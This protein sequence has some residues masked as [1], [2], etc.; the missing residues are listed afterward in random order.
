MPAKLIRGEEVGDKVQAEILAELK[1]LRKKTEKV[2][3][4]ALIVVD[5]NP[6]SLSSVYSKEE[7]GKKLGFYT[8]VHRLPATVTVEEICTV[9]RR[10]N[11]EEQIHGLFC[12]LPLPGHLPENVI[13]DAIAPDKDV[14]GMHPL[15]A[16]KLLSEAR[17]YWPCRAYGFMQAIEF[18]KQPVYGKTAVLI[19]RSNNMGKPLALLLLRR[20]AAVTL[21]PTLT[22][23]LPEI[24]RSA[25]ILVTEAGKPGLIRGDWIKPGAVVIDASV[26]LRGEKLVGDLVLEEVVKVAGWVFPLTADEAGPLTMMM[27]MKNTLEA[28]KERVR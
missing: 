14:G 20:N 17:G 22:G 28:F 12:Q 23:E 2:P 26:T 3:G 18:A 13:L 24:C 7:L 21:C 8:G 5:E 10:L 16:G 4:L 9:I 25:D 11:S 19:S 1:D 6:A 27:L 15:N